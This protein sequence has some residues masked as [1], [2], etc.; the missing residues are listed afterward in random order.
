MKKRNRKLNKQKITELAEQ[1]K[2]EL[3]RKLPVAIL[4]DGGMVYKNYLVKQNKT[5]QWSLYNYRNKELIATFFLKT[6]ALMA[7]KA[8]NYVHLEKFGEIKRLDSSYWASYTDRQVFQHNIK[9]AKEF[10]RYLILL[11]RL[12]ESQL[13]EQQY[14]E[15]ISRMFKWTFV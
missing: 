8:H 14:K 5:N 2:E 11:N 6:C 1:F 13:R 3:D 15:E 10:E 12:E 7:A 4:P 9:T